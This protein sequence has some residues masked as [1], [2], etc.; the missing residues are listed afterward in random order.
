MRRA[1]VLPVDR[2]RET[3]VRAVVEGHESVSDADAQVLS[4]WTASR[5]RAPAR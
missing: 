3:A 1:L 4:A 5:A 2:R